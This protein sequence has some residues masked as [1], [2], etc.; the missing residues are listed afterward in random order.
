MTIQF[1]HA[2]RL[3][4][5]LAPCVEVGTTYLGMRRVIPIIGGTFL[6]ERLR[7]NILSGGADW[8]VI[9]PDGITHVWARY[10]IQTDDGVVISIINEGLGRATPEEMARISSGHA[11]ESAN[12]YTR[13]S[14]KFEVAG[15]KYRWLTQA[16]FVGD[17]LPPREPDSVS[18]EIYEIL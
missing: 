12:W 11:A 6:G 2:F 7:G 17:L 18:I 5:K 8:N 9:R 15:E 16:M 13:T 4:V 1:K 10:E 3:D 14:P